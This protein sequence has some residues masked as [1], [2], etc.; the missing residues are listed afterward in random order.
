MA[1]AVDRMR[2]PGDPL[3]VVAVG[4]GSLLVPDVL[5]GFGDVL[6]PGH[7]EVANAVGAAIAQV[8]GDVDRVFNVGEGRRA[9]VL[10]AAKAEAVDRAVAAGADPATVGIV[11]VDEVPI[12]YLP[13]GA[14]RI[15]VKAVGDLVLG[16]TSGGKNS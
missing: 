5:P 12:A 11:D 13:G 1:D 6:R 9:D 15:R 2:P 16:R 8:S 4:G 14:T 7:F 10:E 3:P